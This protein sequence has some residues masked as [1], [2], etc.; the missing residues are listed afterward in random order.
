M[1]KPRG[2]ATRARP[3]CGLLRFALAAALAAGLAG[4]GSI[5]EQTASSAFLSPGKFDVY[6]CKDIDTRIK[7]VR[8]RQ[9]ELE[10]LMARAS[11]GAGGEFINSVAYRSE[12]L[13]AR[14]ELTELNKAVSDKR[15]GSES[16]WSSGRAVF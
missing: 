6:T 12:Y 3:G 9:L 15:C 11:Q 4:C 13:Q 1:S 5:S 8:I 16:P 10:Q 7:A 14:G 2:E